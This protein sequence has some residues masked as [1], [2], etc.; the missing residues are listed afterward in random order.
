MAI[1]TG[2]DSPI[3]LVL[4]Y[5][6]AAVMNDNAYATRENFQL[7]L[8]ERCSG[9]L[10]GCFRK[11]D[12]T[13]RRYPHILD[14][15]HNMKRGQTLV[16]GDTSEVDFSGIPRQAEHTQCDTAPGN[17]P[18]GVYH[19]EDMLLLVKHRLGVLETLGD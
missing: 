1:E 7:Y 12:K 15:I 9:N 16:P 6:V 2:V 19:D 8:S 13:S 5:D 3:G 18:V 4:P 14:V 11:S 10:K 17:E